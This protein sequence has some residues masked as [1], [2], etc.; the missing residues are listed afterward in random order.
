MFL[1]VTIF[2]TVAAYLIIKGL[3]QM[4]VMMLGF[5]ETDDGEKYWDLRPAFY[6]FLIVFAFYLAGEFGII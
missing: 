4:L 2:Y 3:L 5:H 6:W 1:F